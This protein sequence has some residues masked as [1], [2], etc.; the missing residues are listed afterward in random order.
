[1]SRHRDSKNSGPSYVLLWGDFEGGGELCLEDG[2]IYSDK[3]TWHGPM[4]G[5]A[6]AHWVAAHKKGTRFSAVAFSGG[7]APKTR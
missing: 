3:N 5:A 2:T 7:P 1:M 6:V 4:N